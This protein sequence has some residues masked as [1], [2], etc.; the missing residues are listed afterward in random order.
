MPIGAGSIKRAAQTADKTA[1][2]V[3]EVQKTDKTAAKTIALQDTVNQTEK[4]QKA[5]GAAE[6]KSGTGR[7]AKRKNQTG[8]GAAEKSSS[9]GR[10]AAQ[11]ETEQKTYGILEELPIYLL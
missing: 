8:S 1:A 7:T 4:F 11:K 2:A 10:A 3:T 9:T 5:A 6:K